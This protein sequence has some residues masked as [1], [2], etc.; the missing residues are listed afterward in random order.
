MNETKKR[1]ADEIDGDISSEQPNKKQKIADSD[2][3]TASEASDWISIGSHIF[4]VHLEADKFVLLDTT[5][6]TR[7]K[8]TKNIFNK[9]LTFALEE[10]WNILREGISDMQKII[11]FKLIV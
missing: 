6:G 11:S 4:T 10:P 3:D 7:R 8:Y 9:I 2:Q 1:S 5:S